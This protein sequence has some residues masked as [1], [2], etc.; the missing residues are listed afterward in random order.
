MSPLSPPVFYLHNENAVKKLIHIPSE[1]PGLSGCLPFKHLDL[2]L[3]VNDAVFT[4]QYCKDFFS[5]A[6]LD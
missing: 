1:A 4:R 5:T 6:A 3:H 2:K